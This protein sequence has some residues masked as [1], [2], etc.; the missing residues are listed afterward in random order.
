MVSP[1]RYLPVANSSRAHRASL[2]LV[3]LTLCTMQGQA[4]TKGPDAGNYTATDATAYSFVDI[5]GAS[6]GASVLANTDD[7]LSVLTLPFTFQFYGNAY[8]KIC[9]SSNG[10]LYFIANLTDC[11]GFNDFFNTDLTSTPAPVDHDLPA[12]FPF[13]SDLSF[14]PA[15]AGS[16]LYQ[17][18][19]A[20]AGSRKFVVQWN[21]AFPQGKDGVS[22]VPVTFQVVLSEGSNQV[23]FQYK[24]VGLGPAN[25]ASNGGKA[26]IGIR[27]AAGLT[28]NRQLPWSY[29][30]PVVTDSSA[31][32]FIGDRT[33][34]VITAVPNPSMIW[35]PTG[36]DV[37]VVVSGQITDESGINPT[38]PHYAV[39]DS[40]GQVSLS[41]AVVPAADGSYSFTILLPASRQDADQI[42]RIFSVVVSASD[43]AG[44]SSSTTALVT[45]PHDQ[46]K[47]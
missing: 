38:S 19:P 20:N 3:L 11:T 15:G 5:S 34:P 44:N 13:W 2:L 16:V 37:T 7:G 30:A 14:Q 36:K 46:A 24:T 6:G 21:K 35:P 4:A 27:N 29:S 18:P 1:M 40:Y 10:A 39:T 9:V 22:P 43:T 26:T 41:G 17:T 42:G 45:V 25:V 12:L 33:P 47:K 23:L 8:T 28:D 31:L 32:I